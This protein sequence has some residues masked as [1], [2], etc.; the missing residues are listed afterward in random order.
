[1]VAMAFV[2]LRFLVWAAFLPAI[3]S[4]RVRAAFFAAR[5]RFVSMGVP[6]ESF[7]V[8]CRQGDI[9]GPWLL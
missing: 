2:A 8:G 7:I 9:L 1:M 6:F 4:L 5:L 3:L